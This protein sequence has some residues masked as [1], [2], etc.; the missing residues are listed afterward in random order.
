MCLPGDSNSIKKAGRTNHHHIPHPTAALSACPSAR[1][2]YQ[3]QGSFRLLC[4]SRVGG[5]EQSLINIRCHRPSASFFNSSFAPWKK[6]FSTIA[7]WARCAKTGLVRYEQHS[8]LLP[9]GSLVATR[10]NISPRVK[11]HINGVFK[12]SVHT[13][14]YWPATKEEWNV[15]CSKMSG[16]RRR[17]M[18]QNQPGG[19]THCTVLLYMENSQS[20][21]GKSTT[22]GW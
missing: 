16:T 19:G 10:D 11:H 13:A 20:G 22:R 15:T 14:K 6:V 9:Q 21:S 2:S 4:G 7:T 3:S 5:L 8:G 18:L 1:L 12:C 17:H